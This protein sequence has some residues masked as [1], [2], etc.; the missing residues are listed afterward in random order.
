MVFMLREMQTA[1][2]RFWTW[3][4]KSTSNDNNPYARSTSFKSW[5]IYLLY[6]WPLMT[7]GSTALKKKEKDLYEKDKNLE[8]VR[9]N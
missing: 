8:L 5:A 1:L 9:N 2:F 4:G 7:R 3:I 6:S